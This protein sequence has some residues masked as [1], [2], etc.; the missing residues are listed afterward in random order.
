M[1]GQAADITACAA[2]YLI[3]SVPI[4]LLAGKA[5]RGVDVRDLGSGNI[6]TTNVYRILGPS[7]AAVTFALDVAKGAGAVVLAEKMGADRTGQAAAGLAAVVGHSWPLFARF[8][9]GKGV[10]TGFGA[11]LI[12]SPEATAYAIVGG[13]AALVVTRIVSVGSL[14]A[15]MSATLGA[16]VHVIRT[17][18]AV[19][20]AFSALVTAL[21]AYRHRDNLKRLFRGQEPRLSWGKR[22]G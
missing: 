17:S 10:A 20:L 9:G 11:I 3:G 15:A 12:V 5:I 8:R 4:G 1:A 2:G 7:A 14:S 13:V 16:T 6:G 18:D 22:S 19:P 21:I